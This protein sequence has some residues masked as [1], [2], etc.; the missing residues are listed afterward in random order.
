MTYTA[1]QFIETCKANV[2][3]LEGLTTQAFTGFEKLVE[4]NISTAKSGMAEAF[5][6]VHA[7]L[8]AKDAQEVLNLQTSLLQHLVEKSAAYGQHV[9]DLSSGAGSEF[10][11]I[12]E[13]M[14]ADAKAALAKLVDTVEKNAPAGAE[15]AVAAFK[16]AVN[17][18]HDLIDSAQNSAKKAVKLAESKLKAATATQADEATTVTAKMR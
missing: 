7:V 12:Y 15:P 2:Q 1:E 11:H 10:N 9:L 5:S 13:S 18:S 3:K 14:L 16:N 17:A 4:L 6:H 8:S